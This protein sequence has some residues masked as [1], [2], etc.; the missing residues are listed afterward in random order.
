MAKNAVYIPSLL[1]ERDDFFFKKLSLLFDKIYVNR[2]TTVDLLRMFKL[3]VADKANSIYSEILDF[4]FLVEK[5]IVVLSESLSTLLED[6]EHIPGRVIF[7][8]LRHQ[9][10]IEGIKPD[11]NSKFLE[12]SQDFIIRLET[13]VLKATLKEEF[14]PIVSSTE[15]YNEGKKEKVVQFILGE[16]PEPDESVSWEQIIEFRSDADVKNKYFAL[17]HWINKVSVST[18]SLSDIKD[19]YNVLYSDYMKAFTLHQMK[20]NYSKVQIIVSAGVDCLLSIAT[21]HFIPAVKNLLSMK[22]SNI[23]LMQEEIKITGKEIA[24]I[25]RANEE[26]KS[27]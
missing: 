19:E 13:L 6:P 5:N 11:S 18:A 7:E 1:K 22:L 10:T 21:G 25:Y 15:S 3:I 24:Y 8:A 23:N 20:Y 12:A 2:I 27:V 26:F 9:V 16:M 14:Y 4:D 17:I